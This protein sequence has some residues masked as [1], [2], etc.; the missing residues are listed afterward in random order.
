M[1]QRC[2]PALINI[3]SQCGLRAVIEVGCASRFMCVH[4]WTWSI[5][6]WAPWTESPPGAQYS[7]SQLGRQ[8]RSWCFCVLP[9]TCEYGSALWKR[10]DPWQR[11]D[12]LVYLCQL[13]IQQ[14]VVANSLINSLIILYRWN[15]KLFALGLKTIEAGLSKASQDFNVTVPRLSI[16]HPAPGG[17]ETDGAQVVL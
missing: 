4:L 8:H 17:L 7:A 15:H 11:G 10:E 16:H 12:L 9:R 2:C 14:H 3:S 6:L 13:I 5:V 1:L